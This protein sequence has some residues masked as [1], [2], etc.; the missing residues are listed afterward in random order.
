MLSSSC[1]GDGK[2][3]IDSKSL[4]LVDLLPPTL[5]SLRIY[6]RGQAMHPGAPYLDYNS[7]LDVDAQIEQLA[8][9]KDAKLPGLSVLECVEPRIPNGWH[10]YPRQQDYN[11]ELH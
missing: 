8:R 5:E 1:A 4:N 3:R 2:S 10:M 9:E 11:P 7:D 6:G